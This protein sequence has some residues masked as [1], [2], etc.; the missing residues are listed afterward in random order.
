MII[1]WV[2]ANYISGHEHGVWRSPLFTNEDAAKHFEETV[3][4]KLWWSDEPWYSNDIDTRIV[5]DIVLDDYNNNDITEDE[6][7]RLFLTITYT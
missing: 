7:E 6:S 1:F 4:K 5:T 2:E 3:A